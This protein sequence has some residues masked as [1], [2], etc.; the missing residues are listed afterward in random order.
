MLLRSLTACLTFILSPFSFEPL[1]Y[2]IK[3][4][5]SINTIIYEFLQTYGQFEGYH[6]GA[7]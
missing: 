6:S 3:L 4:T 5:S 2:F 7:R 1:Y